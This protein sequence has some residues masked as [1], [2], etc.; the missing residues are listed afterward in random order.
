MSDHVYKV[1]ELVGSSP[2]SIEDAI[3]GA[4]GRASQTI[5]NL[6]WFEVLETRGHIEDGRV[7]HYQVTLKVG[8]TMEGS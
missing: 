7:H 6:R 1:V 5:R 3:Q 4:V 8:F 2:N